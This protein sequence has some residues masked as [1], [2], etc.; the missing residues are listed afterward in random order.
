[1]KSTIKGLAAA[2]MLMGI[3]ACSKMPQQITQSEIDRIHTG[4]SRADVESILGQ[5]TGEK[6]EPIPL[7]GGTK[8]TLEYNQKQEHV[9]VVL[10]NDSF[11][12]IEAHAKQD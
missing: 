5:P 8:T 12:T 10:K 1:V 3:A 7:V 2:A 11:Q 4:M 6:S 9:I